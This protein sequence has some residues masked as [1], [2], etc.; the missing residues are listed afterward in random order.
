VRNVSLVVEDMRG[1]GGSCTLCRL[2]VIVRC[3]KSFSDCDTSCLTTTL[4][5]AS[6][7]AA[8]GAW[9]MSIVNQRR[10]CFTLKAARGE[11]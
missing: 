9:A 7:A 4:R 11:S 1:E 8:A 6:T 3:S 2:C 10:S 5:E